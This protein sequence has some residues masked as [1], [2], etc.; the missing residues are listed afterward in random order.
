MCLPTHKLAMLKTINL[1]ELLS[2]K[3]GLH[4]IF[5]FGFDVL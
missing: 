3:M 2:N 5:I 4:S 1:Y